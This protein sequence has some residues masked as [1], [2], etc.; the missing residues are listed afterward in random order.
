MTRANLARFVV[1]G[2]HLKPGNNMPPFRIF[3][4]AELDALSGYLVSLR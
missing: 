3:S 1:D 2:Q 4:A